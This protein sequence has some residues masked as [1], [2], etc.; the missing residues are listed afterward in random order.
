M[1]IM[2]LVLYIVQV[3]EHLEITE[4]HDCLHSPKAET[5]LMPPSEPGMAFM[6]R[7]YD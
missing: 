1:E 4:Y 5:Q 6:S 2:T 3:A 7:K